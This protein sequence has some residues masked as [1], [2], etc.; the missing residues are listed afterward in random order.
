ME[1]LK[2]VSDILTEEA[3]REWSG[4]NP[5]E[6]ETWLERLG[7]CYQLAWRFIIK[8]DEGW[9]I[10]GRVFGGMPP[11]WIEHAWV[12]LPTGLVYEPVA[13]T[14]YEKDTF[15]QG[16]KAEELHRYT[17]T[18]AAKLCMKFGHYGPWY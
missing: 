1:D 16:Y 11:R 5:Q 15:Y 13:D 10:H 2:E 17:P 8:E 7:G 14:F 6:E 9:L 4:G 3:T 18:E 12:E